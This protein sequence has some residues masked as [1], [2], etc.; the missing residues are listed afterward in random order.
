MTKLSCR[1][2]IWTPLCPLSPPSM[3]VCVC[4][5]R[6]YVYV[7]M[8]CAH[9]DKMSSFGVNAIL[10]FGQGTEFIIETKAC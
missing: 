9:E 2:Q 8:Y 7:H 6:D 3:Y 5:P 1:V 10:P 4:I